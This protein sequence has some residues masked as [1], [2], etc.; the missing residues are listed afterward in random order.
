MARRA[1][2]LDVDGTIIDH[3]EALAPP[4]IDAVRGA[5]GHLVFLCTGRALP[6]ISTPILDIGFDG[7]ITA[8]GGYV[9]VGGELIA[10]HAMPL[11]LL[12]HA[13]DFFERERIEY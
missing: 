10:E 8:G 12:R 3:T 9:E 6:E 1:I 7:A 4:G 2:F 11:D 13:V 5:R